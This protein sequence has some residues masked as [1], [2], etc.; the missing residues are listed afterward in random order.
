MPKNGDSESFQFY[1]SSP[2]QTFGFILKSTLGFSF[3]C[4][5]WLQIMTSGNGQT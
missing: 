1:N 3:F 4:K 2:A 5:S